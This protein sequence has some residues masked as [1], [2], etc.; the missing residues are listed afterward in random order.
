[1]KKM[2]GVLSL[3]AIMTV[4]FTV[5]AKEVDNFV[6]TELVGQ[7]EPVTVAFDYVATADSTAVFGGE[8]LTLEAE[9]GGLNYAD[10][11]AGRSNNYMKVDSLTSAIYEDAGEVGSNIVSK[12]NFNYIETGL[13]NFESTSDTGGV[14]SND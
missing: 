1:M 5:Q 13:T 7:F 3:I 10:I 14:N 8:F 6:K 4:A 12:D 9:L 2:F 11:V